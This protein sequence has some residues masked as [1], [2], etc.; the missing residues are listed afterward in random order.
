[1]LP[2][3]LW[4]MHSEWK[5][6]SCP[7][8]N[9]C[10]SSQQR[11]KIGPD[12]QHKQH[13]FFDFSFSIFAFNSLYFVFLFVSKL[14]VVYCNSNQCKLNYFRV[15]IDVQINGSWR[16]Q[17]QFVINNLCDLWPLQKIMQIIITIYAEDLLM[18]N[19]WFALYRDYGF[20]RVSVDKKRYNI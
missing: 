6:I 7:G 10:C 9:P 1:M 8:T 19:I 13:M 3:L 4:L 11:A 17:Q 12:V 14:L 15:F 18:N 20:Y 5:R 2:I 16:K